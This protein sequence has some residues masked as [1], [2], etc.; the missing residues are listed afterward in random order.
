[1]ILT[2][3]AQIAMNYS[4]SQQAKENSMKSTVTTIRNGVLTV[5]P[6]ER[7]GARMF[8]QFRA[9]RK[10]IK[11]TARFLRTYMHMSDKAAILLVSS[12]AV[13]RFT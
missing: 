3:F 6:K 2:Y 10:A 11:K 12:G 7:S 4:H 1:V 9:R 5:G 13:R 8:K